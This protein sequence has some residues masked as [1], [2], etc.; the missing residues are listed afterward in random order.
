MVKQFQLR[1]VR[2]RLKQFLFIWSE[3]RY[4][5]NTL[6]YDICQYIGHLQAI[7]KRLAFAFGEY[8]T[9]SYYR[10]PTFLIDEQKSRW[11]L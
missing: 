6:A 10:I 5:R 4:W 11:I 2:I 1:L 7:V 8:T 9:I 3:K